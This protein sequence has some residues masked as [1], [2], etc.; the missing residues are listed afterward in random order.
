[1]SIEQEVFGFSNNRNTINS[2]QKGNTNERAAAKALESWVGVK[3]VRVPMSGG[4]RRVDTEKITGDI[5]IDTADKDF[6]FPFTL[7]TKHLKHI[8]I[9]RVLRQSSKLFTIWEQAHSDSLRA[10]KIPMAML[11][12]NGMKAGEYYIILDAAQGGAIMG[13]YVD[14]LFSGSNH[15]FNIVGFFLSEI[16]ESLSYPIFSKLIKRSNFVS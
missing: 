1:M 13:K 8:T 11:R 14:V 7:E 9:A 5:I 12:S 6:Y 3:F 10:N 4:L 16:K 15:K 2:K